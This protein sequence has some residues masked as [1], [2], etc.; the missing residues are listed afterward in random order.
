[1]NP[2]LQAQREPSKA[3]MEAYYEKV[4]SVTGNRGRKHS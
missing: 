4:R 2:G 1:M 3:L